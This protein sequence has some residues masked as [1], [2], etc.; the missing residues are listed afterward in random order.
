MKKIYQLVF[1]LAFFQ[2]VILMVNATGVFPNTFYSDSEVDSIADVNDLPTAEEWFIDMFAPDLVIF[3]GNPIFEHRI[4]SVLSIVA[5]FLSIG[6]VGSI[7]MHGNFVPIV[8]AFQ[9]YMIFTMV[10]NSQSFFMKL[11]T[12]W[13]TATLTYLGLLLGL[14]IIILFI[15]TFLEQA[16]HGDA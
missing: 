15:V 4:A 12:N 5:V 11:I 3:E 6:V 10:V 9:G 13:D 7:A 2:G 8:L 16:S 1:I 14:G